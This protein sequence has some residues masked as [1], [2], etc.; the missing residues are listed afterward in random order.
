MTTIP[1]WNPPVE[2]TPEEDDLLARL[3]RVRKLFGFLR[4]HRHE[5]FDDAFQDVLEQMYRD[6]GAGKD[7][8]PPARMAMA[9]VLQGYMNVSDAEA[10]ELT[11]MDRRWQLVLDC[12]GATDPVFSQGALQAF[13]ERMI[14]HDMDLRLCDRIREF[15]RE[16]GEFDWKKLPKDLRLAV[17]SAPFDG[18]GRVED[19]YNLLGHAARKIVELLASILEQPR[20]TIAE[21]ARIPVLNAS[22]VKAGLDVDWTDESASSD[23]INELVSQLDELQAWIERQPLNDSEA[24]AV[25]DNV[26]VLAEVRA[27]NVEVS[28]DG[29][30]LVRIPHRVPK[31]RRIS[32]EDAEMRHGRKSS[33]QRIDG[34]KRHIAR[35]LDTGLIWACALTAANEPEADA[36][37]DI[38]EQVQRQAR[39]I[40]ELYI[41]RA[42]LSSD[43]VDELAGNG[44]EV[45]CRPWSPRNRG[46]LFT[47]AAFEIDTEQ[48]K[49]TCPNGETVPIPRLGTTVEFPGG[50]C[51]GCPLRDQCTTRKRGRGR[52]VRI[53]EDEPL[54]QRLK[55]YTA[56]P[57]GRAKHR[58]RVTVEHGLAHLC[59]RQGPRARYLGKRKNL[60]DVRRSAAIQN[61]ETVQRSLGEGYYRSAA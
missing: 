25:D 40:G 26:T 45:V 4:R 2:T 53:A 43:V 60:Y 50:E 10:V 32:I 20:N 28:P 42:Y 17:D 34:Y 56:T 9:T 41:D 35:D 52:T 24:S 18:A 7:P 16:T 39:S 15:A 6:T 13:R 8:R 31:D 5:L 59:A 19:E 46:K 49:I 33:R 61:L 23:A 14:E 1:R 22:S 12:L 30:G 51:D 36:L 38:D 3:G 47:K 48:M 44:G 58:E 11:V 27:Q 54:Q 37:S 55:I 29:P 57:A 21:A